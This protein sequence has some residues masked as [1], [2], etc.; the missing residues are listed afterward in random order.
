MG[1]AIYLYDNLDSYTKRYKE[2]VEDG[3]DKNKV[4]ESALPVLDLYIKDKDK[5]WILLNTNDYSNKI[6]ATRSITFFNL[7]EFPTY[8][9]GN[10]RLVLDDKITYNPKNDKI[11]FFP[12]LFRK[13]EL[14]LHVS[15]FNGDKPKKKTKINYTH[16][17]YDLKLNRLNLVLSD[18]K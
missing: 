3:I 5:L 2:F 6:N 13:C 7:K 14:E 17:F 1:T 4:N 18:S 8:Y 16:R 11:R 12:R 9:T 15:K 10:E